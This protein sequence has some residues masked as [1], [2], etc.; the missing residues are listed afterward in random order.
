MSG[1]NG[2][3][4]TDKESRPI[5]SNAHLQIYTIGEW[6]QS[7]RTVNGTQTTYHSPYLERTASTQP[8]ECCKA[9]KEGEKD[10]NRMK[11]N[12]DKR[13]GA[14]NLKPLN[15]GDMVWI[16]ERE[17]GGTVEKE[18]NTRS[19]TVRTGDGMLRRNRRNLILM[20]N[21]T[22]AQQSTNT[23]SSLADQSDQNQVENPSPTDGT[24][25][26]SGR[27]SKPPDRLM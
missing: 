8:P 4:T 1:Q 20:S 19:Y 3:T 25:T 7:S 2:E 13:H 5:L 12:F 26:R 15:P 22:E 6:L 27:V 17:A 16:P 9:Q 23:E 10:E 18:S 11:R 14:K 24:K 21:T